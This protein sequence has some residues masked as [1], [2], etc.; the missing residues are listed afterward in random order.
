MAARTLLARAGGV[1]MWPGIALTER[2]GAACVPIAADIAR[3]WISRLHGPEADDWAVL[4]CLA[5]AA[6]KLSEGDEAGAQRALDASGPI[7]LSADGVVLVRAVAGSLGIG[8]LDLPWAE[9]PRL[10]R[11]RDI[12][13]HLPL[14][15]DYAPH[16]GLARQGGASDEFLTSALAWWLSRSS[17]WPVQ[18]GEG[19]PISEGRSVSSDNGGNGEHLPEV[20]R[21]DHRRERGVERLSEAPRTGSRGKA[22]PR[23]C[24]DQGILDGLGGDFVDQ[25]RDCQYL[26]LLGWAKVAGRVATRGR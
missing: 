15:K 5:I 16:G 21:S 6:Q 7:R 19:G 22:P 3:F 10:W 2:R 11:A 12:A 14:F 13:A 1:F 8:P 23:A 18:S 9:G 17:R 26:V 25:R 20:P 24:P 4:R